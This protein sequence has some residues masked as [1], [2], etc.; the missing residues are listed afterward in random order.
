MGQQITQYGTQRSREKGQWGTQSGESEGGK[1]KENCFRNF[2]CV[3]NG[4]QQSTLGFSMENN[5]R[6]LTFSSTPMAVQHE[7]TLDYKLLP[8]MIVSYSRISSFNLFSSVY[9]KP[10]TKRLLLQLK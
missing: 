7:G 10:V 1:E 9:P 5:I 8:G 4:W 6:T 2:S 3:G